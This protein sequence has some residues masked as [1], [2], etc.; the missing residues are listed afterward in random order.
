MFAIHQGRIWS[1]EVSGN[2]L[3][4]IN[5][6]VISCIYY[7]I[8]LKDAYIQF[9][10]KDLFYKSFLKCVYSVHFCPIPVDHKL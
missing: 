5:F 4:C 2:K 9:L 7:L 10:K 8:Y 6:I 1:R 3:H